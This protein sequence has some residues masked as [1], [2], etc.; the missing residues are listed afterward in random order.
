LLVHQTVPNVPK[1]V[2]TAFEVIETLPA[3]GKT[4]GKATLPH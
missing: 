2:A 3:S 4:A 1:D